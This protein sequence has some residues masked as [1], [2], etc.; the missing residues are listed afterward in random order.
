MRK[1]LV[2]AVVLG[3][4][5]AGDL[6]VRTVAES[7]LRDRVVASASPAGGTSARIRSFPF[8]GRLLTS[9]RVSRIE[10]STAEVTVEGVTFARVALDLRG[11]T[12]DRDALV[13]KQEVRLVSLDRGTASA[14]VTQAELSERLGVAVT[15]TAGR[16]QVRIGGQTVTAGASVNDDVLQLTVAGQS[17]P[18]LRIPKPRMLP[19]VGDVEIVPGRVR[20]TCTLD[21]LPDELVQK[22]LNDLSP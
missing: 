4:L 21:R 6:A 14:E 19:C 18:R 5:V 1:L 8:V 12:F 3:L 15:L 9:G 11:V 17:L 22:L 7:Q 2:L 10:V 16:A 20:F 13:S